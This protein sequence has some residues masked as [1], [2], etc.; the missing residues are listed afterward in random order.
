MARVC[1][2]G[3]AT[4]DLIRTGLIATR[5]P[6]GTMLYASLALDALGHDVCPIGYAPLRAYVMLRFAGVDT[7]GLK[8]ALRGTRF[9][10]KYDGQEREQW[11][12]EGPTKALDDASLL[13]D[14]DAIL[15]GP[16]LG[17]IPPDLDVPAEVPSVLDVQGTIR[18]LGTA[19]LWGYQRVHID[20]SLDQTPP[21][22]YVRGSLEEVQPLL[23][24]SDVAQAAR[25]LAE[26]AGRPAI[27]TDGPHGAVG[28]DQRLHTVDTI[29][30]E[31][32]DP[33]G[34][35]DVFDAG[36]LYGLLEEEPL[37]KALLYGCALAGLFLENDQETRLTHRFPEAS[38]LE[39]RVAEL[40]ER[41]AS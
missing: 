7:S 12:R 36:L 8:M 33:T 14:A 31:V 16:V 28:F 15:L 3:N 20:A 40:A 10:N 13:Q 6:G 30:L 21:S 17:E 41:D 39:N 1:V 23:G 9:L 4:H 37:E 25:T 11:A 5:R 18:R 24:E 29:P 19:N 32:E 34:A 22:R 2:V 27:V 26:R 35:G 38:V